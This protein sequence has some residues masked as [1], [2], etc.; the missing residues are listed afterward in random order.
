MRLRLKASGLS[1]GAG[2]P[3]DSAFSSTNEGIAGSVDILVPVPF[4]RKHFEGKYLNIGG[5]LGGMGTGFSPWVNRDR[6]LN[7]TIYLPAS[8]NTSAAINLQTLELHLLDSR[9]TG[10][11][12]VM[13]PLEEPGAARGSWAVRGPQGWRIRAWQGSDRADGRSRSR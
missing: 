12:H 3:T 4:V 7:L 6:S 8:F 13:L 10:S 9:W 11:R 1:L 5:G 2:I